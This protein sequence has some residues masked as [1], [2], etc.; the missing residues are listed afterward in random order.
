MSQNNR[1]PPKAPQ[2]PPQPPQFKIN[3]QSQQPRVN[4][5]AP[6]STGKNDIQQRNNIS[7]PKPADVNLF[8]ASMV[9]LTPSVVSKTLLEKKTVNNILIETYQFKYSDNSYLNKTYLDGFLI[10]SVD[11][12]GGTRVTYQTNIQAA[13]EF[14]NRQRGPDIKYQPGSG[15]INNLNYDPYSGQNLNPIQ[16]PNFDEPNL[17]PNYQNRFLNNLIV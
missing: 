2:P 15:F 14:I 9:Q 4:R 11:P 17:N 5:V 13:N 7:T 6:S 8:K 1:A 3:S 16:R 10:S 12:V